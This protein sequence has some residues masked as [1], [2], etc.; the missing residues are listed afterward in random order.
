MT[1]RMAGLLH[2]MQATAAPRPDG[3]Q[4]DVQYQLRLDDQFLELGPWLGKSLQL[5]WSGRIFCCHCGRQTRKSFSQGY[6]YPCM[7]T[8]AQC[9]RCMMSPEL[10]HY[11]Q[12]TCREPEWAR[13]VCFQPHYVYLANSSGIKVGI[14]RAGQVPVRWLDQGAVQGM[15]IAK[16]SSRRLSGLIENRLKSQV[17]DKTNWRTMLKGVSA[18]LDLATMARPLVE[19][20]RGEEASM[21]VLPGDELVEWLP[22]L[23]HSFHY[24]VLQYPAKVVSLD[25]D[26]QQLVN[27]R[28]MGIKGQY[29]M[30]DTGVINLRKY[31][32]YEISVHL[33]D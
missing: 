28:L 30:L 7:Q 2:K 4:S 17:A 13:S 11:Q 18:S 9:D 20:V 31:N 8:L 21:T 22:L 10:C 23:S 19:L 12:G 24:P 29:L 26:K 25:L 27:G 6:C 16:V 32:R 3:Q 5:R 1:F 15:C 14:T 33:D